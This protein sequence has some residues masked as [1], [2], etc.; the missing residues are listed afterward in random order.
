MYPVA[1]FYRFVS[2]DDPH[3]L[4]RRI[5]EVARTAGVR[6][7]ILVALE[8]INGTIA[9]T[10]DAVDATLDF[11]REQPGFGGIA[12]KFSTHTS[13]PFK[14]LKVQVKAEIVTLGVGHV[15]VPRMTGIRVG[16]GEWNELLAD[17]DVVVIDARN[18]F[19]V[20]SG[21]F[22]N[23]IN[24][25]TRSFAE[26]PDWA[27]SA[28][29]LADKPKLAM[30]CTGGIRCEKASAYLADVGFDEIYQLDG[31]ILSYL[32]TVSPSDSAW[33][34][35]CVVFDDRQT[36]DHN[37]SAGALEL[38]HACSQPITSDDRT[39]PGYERGVSCPRCHATVSDEQRA[40][41]RERQHQLDLAKS[42]E[43][44]DG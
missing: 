7:T 36:L 2:V 1:T 43:R 27:N 8:G 12:A 38:C 28:A 42:R 16:V 33:Q 23:A 40:S 6:G 30:F 26:F 44:V 34:G 24:P 4:A 32:E 29:E 15:D 3:Q 18:D 9:G 39:K 10:D 19:E 14:R 17:P 37:L 22:P 13:L 11:L 35:E 31:G 41:F 21:T 20:R 25:G 5:R